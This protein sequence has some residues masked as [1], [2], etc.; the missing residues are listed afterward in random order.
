MAFIIV[1]ALAAGALI[2]FIGHHHGASTSKGVVADLESTVHRLA[3]RLGLGAPAA[4]PN[5]TPPKTEAK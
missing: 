4:S 1:A 3:N 5:T 2:F